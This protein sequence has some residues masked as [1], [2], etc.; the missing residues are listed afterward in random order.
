[1]TMKPSQIRS[2]TTRQNHHNRLNQ[3]R[4]SLVQ[5]LTGLQPLIVTSTLV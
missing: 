3:L 4:T 5:T 1:M 2:L